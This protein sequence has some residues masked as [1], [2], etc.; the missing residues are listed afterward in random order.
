MWARLASGIQ[1][2]QAERRRKD[3]ALHGTGKKKCDSS[4]RRR[5][6]RER[7]GMEEGEELKYKLLWLFVPPKLA[8]IQKIS[9]QRLSND[10]HP[11]G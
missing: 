6:K 3:M 10:D 11:A 5:K 8:L 4:S 2:P 1:V 9:D 7:S